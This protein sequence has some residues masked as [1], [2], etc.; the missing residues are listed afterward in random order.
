MALLGLLVATLE[1]SGLEALRSP[2]EE[3]YGPKRLTG[4][5]EGLEGQGPARGAS[6]SVAHVS[7][8]AAHLGFWARAICIAVCV[9]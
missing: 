7:H 6:A 4:W 9:A 1:G 3:A 5:F 8:F 2:I